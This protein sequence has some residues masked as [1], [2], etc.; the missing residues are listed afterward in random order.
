MWKSEG[1][2]TPFTHCILPHVSDDAR[3]RPQLSA[4]SPGSNLSGPHGR[5][6]WKK[7]TLK[8]WDCLINR[9]A[10]LSTRI[11]PAI[12]DLPCL[13]VEEAVRGLAESIAMSRCED[14]HQITRSG[15]RR[16]R[17]AQDAQVG[18]ASRLH[19]KVTRKDC[20][21][22]QMMNAFYA[23]RDPIL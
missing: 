5:G 4:L 11:P 18:F 6:C 9:M 10:H 17:P 12:Q 20:Q 22:P 1:A 3:P 21:F 23:R 14:N 7:V 15:G 13:M 16:Q 2:G 19:D 8:T